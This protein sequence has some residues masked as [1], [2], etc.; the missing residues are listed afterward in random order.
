[1][2]KP[3]TLLLVLAA[4]LSCSKDSGTGPTFPA[5]ISVIPDSTTVNL[6]DHVQ[7]RA[8]VIN[9]KGDTLNEA[10]SWSASPTTVA[11][12]SPTGLTQGLTRGTATIHA[13]LDGVEGLARVKVKIPVIQVQLQPTGGTLQVGDTLRIKDT[14]IT[15]NGQLPDDSIVSWTSS[16]TTKAVVSATGL[17]TGR[18]QGSVTISARVDSAV[19][20]A[21]FSVPEPVTKIILSAHFDTLRQDSAFQVTA[22]PI[23]TANDTIF[24]HAVTWSSSDTAVAKISPNS[25]DVGIGAYQAGRAVIRAQIGSAFDSCV[26]IVVRPSVAAIIVSP[27]TGKKILPGAFALHAVIKDSVGVVLT[28]RLITWALSDT[29]LADLA[30][31]TG[32]DVTVTGKKGG[33]ERAYAMSEGM[34]DSALLTFV[35]PS[36]TAEH[37]VPDTGSFV[38]PTQAFFGLNAIVLDSVNDTLTDRI[39]TWTITDTTIATLSPLTGPGTN[40]IGKKGGLAVVIA[41]TEGHVDT[42]R[43]DVIRPSVSKVVITPDT[44]T[45]VVPGEVTV[46]STIEDSLGQQLFGRPTHWAVVDT[47]IGTISDTNGDYINVGGKAPGIARIVASAEGVTDT[48]YV[49]VIVPSV[50]QVVW[51]PPADTSHLLLHSVRSITAEALDSN[52]TPLSRPITFASTDSAITGFIYTSQSGPYAFTQVKG[53]TVGSAT[54]SASAGGKTVTWD[55]SIYSVGYDTVGVGSNESCMPATDG[56]VYCWGKN[57]NFPFPTPVATPAGIHGLT[58]KLALACG[59]DPSGNAYCWGSSSGPDGTSG[60]PGYDTARAVT[61]GTQFSQ[62]DVG[63]DHI[64]GV[65]AGGGLSCW[66]NNDKAQLGLGDSSARTQ[67]TNLS[68]GTTF[69]SVSAGYDHTCAVASSGAAYCWGANGSGQ[70]G[71]PLGGDISPM[72]VSGAVTF[73]VVSAGYDHSCGLS[74]T[75]IAYCWGGNTYGQLGTGDTASRSAPVA[76]AGGLTF[77]SIAAGLLSTCGVTTGG[78]AYCWGY[79]GYLALGTAA[80]A[81][82]SVPVAVTG[83]LTFTSI[84]AGLGGNA[85]V[86]G[87]TMSGAYCWGFGAAGGGTDVPVKIP[88]QP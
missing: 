15:A 32:T 64:C 59:L 36:V 47:A 57:G 50:A 87:M 67:P 35:R 5:S 7:L 71:Q 28:Q 73:S 14:L 72:P 33:V 74:S 52:G 3:T 26:I 54:V 19:A 31:A 88:G 65:T 18:A 80:H 27:D 12:V 34:T 78:A 25:F 21:I 17:V 38:I 82:S 81:N 24:T 2:R 70:A 75:G 6:F 16:D 10:V 53:L 77:K 58:S 79:D 42:A 62:V 56:L 85:N 30:P 9:N 68:L 83:G 22:T 1:M 37:V 23:G 13:A 61:G 8:V 66:G 45:I 48:A 63:W 29:S 39:T 69:T 40:V 76:V 49:H 86:C 20:H 41:A 60:A 43:I 4:G 46:S 11:Y 51:S 55:A 44:A 84:G